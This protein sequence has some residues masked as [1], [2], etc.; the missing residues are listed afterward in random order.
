MIPTELALSLEKI[1]EERA[2]DGIGAKFRRALPI[3]LASGAGAGLGWGAGKLVGHYVGAPVARLLP[4]P[5][6]A[7]ATAALSGYAV[8]QQRKQQEIEREELARAAKNPNN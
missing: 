6:L 3:I 8:K 2:R 1:A 4:P 7:L 5:A